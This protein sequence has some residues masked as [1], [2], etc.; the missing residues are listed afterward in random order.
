MISEHN[1]VFLPC[2]DSLVKRDWRDAGVRDEDMP[3][4]RCRFMHRYP[5]RG[6]HGEPLVRDEGHR[7]PGY[8][9]FRGVMCDAFFPCRCRQTP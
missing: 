6:P 4:D 1:G 7:N 5:T 9:V 3:I 2:G 8:F